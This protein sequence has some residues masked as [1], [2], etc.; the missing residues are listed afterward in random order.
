MSDNKLPFW[1]ERKVMA[2]ILFANNKFRIPEFQRNYS[3]GE[4]QIE[5]FW[6]DLMD[7]SDSNFIGSFVLNYENLK[8]EKE[9]N[10]HFGYIDII[11]GQQRVI[12]I[13]LFLAVIR[14]IAKIEKFTELANRIQRNTLGF[15]DPVDGQTTTRI[16]CGESLHDFYLT[17]VQNEDSDIFSVVTS[18]KEK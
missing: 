12:T 9:E 5:D 6:N 15:E 11:D 10:P 17:N 7:D 8:I 2:E 1:P 13:S 16:I 18:E 14:N 3:W 4:D